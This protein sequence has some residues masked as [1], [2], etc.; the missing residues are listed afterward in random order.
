[1]E[2]GS[3]HRNRT[4]YQKSHYFCTRFQSRAKIIEITKSLPSS[5]TSNVGQTIQRYI[6]SQ[7]FFSTF[8]RGVGGGGE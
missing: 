7:I 3:N 6:V 4:K 5:P 8:N 1:V 2:G